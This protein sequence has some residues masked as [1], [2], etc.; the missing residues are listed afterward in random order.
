[1]T[2]REYKFLFQFKPHYKTFDPKELKLYRLVYEK[3]EK[4]LKRIRIFRKKISEIR[5]DIFLNFEINWYS[6]R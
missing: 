5:S 3:S 2:T 1:V 4:N 6:G